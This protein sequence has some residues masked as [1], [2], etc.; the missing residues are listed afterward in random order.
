MNTEFEA[1]FG[2]PPREL[3]DVSAAPAQYSP[4]HPGAL[5]IEEAAPGSLGNLA[6]LAPPGTVERRYAIALALRALR[7]GA[8]LLAMAPKDKGGSRLAGDLADLGCAVEETSRRHHRICLARAPGDAG[9]IEAAIAAGAPQRVEPLGLW[10][11]PGVFSWNRLDPGTALLMESLP[12]L[13]GRGA[14]FGCGIGMLSRAALANPDVTQLAMIDMD[15]RAID[16]ARRNITDAR[17]KFLW[18]MRANGTR[19]SLISSS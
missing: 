7:E 4:L 3:A 2:E 18:R 15:R 13:K 1:I 6:M 5:C 19:R 16:A 10:S 12:R 14:D 17:A 9:A 11:Q 8:P